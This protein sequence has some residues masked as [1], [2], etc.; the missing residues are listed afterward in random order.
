LV[1]GRSSKSPTVIFMRQAEMAAEAYAKLSMNKIIQGIGLQN[2]QESSESVGLLSKPPGL[3]APVFGQFGM[4]NPS[5][6]KNSPI[7]RPQGGHV[8]LNIASRDKLKDTEYEN[9]D[10]VASQNFGKQHTDMV[11][12]HNSF[13]YRVDTLKN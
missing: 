1:R 11:P 8:L 7:T 10:E 5:T 13:G 4:S 12:T 6:L 3:Q 2:K 9:L